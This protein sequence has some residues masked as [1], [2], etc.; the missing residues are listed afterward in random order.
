M[1]EPTVAVI[2]AGPAGLGAAYEVARTGRR[3]V[4]LERSD[5]IGGLARSFEL[6]G[7]PVELGAH[8]LLRDDPQIDALWNAIIGDRYRRV[9]RDTRIAIAGHLLQY[10]YRSGDVAR[11]LGVRDMARC[12]AGLLRR[13]AADDD[14]SLE[15]WV[16]SRFGR[17]AYELLLSDYLVKL[18]G[19][20]GSE[21]DPGLA[22]SLLGF[23][24]HPTPAAMV[25]RLL[26]GTNEPDVVRPLGG[27]GELLERLAV[28]I[29]AAGGEI[30]LG[31]GIDSIE[32]AAGRVAA[33]HADGEVSPV[34]HLISTLPP[35]HLLRLLP[36]VPPP[37]VAQGDRLT[38]RSVVILYARISGPPPFPGQWLYVADLDIPV[39][40]ITNFSAWDAPGPD[41]ILAFEI[42][43][44]PSEP[45][46][47]A[48]P[49]DLLAH[50]GRALRRAGLT[51]APALD[52][53][54]ERVAGAL[55]V[56]DRA[57]RGAME[58]VQ[59][60]VDEISGL[61]TTGRFGRFVNS[62]THE[63][64][65]LGMSAARAVLAGD[66]R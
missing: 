62:G 55:P 58:A 6:W 38:L 33:V 23:S 42:W 17:P 2:G 32:L 53:H 45:A 3:V 36:G 39:S 26:R 43:C 27:V 4:V 24:R 19:R 1:S 47:S 16:T 10:P 63:S 8:L 7:R 5:R 64:I 15:R 57:H 46:W 51:L 21:L 35:R 37:L 41:S 48:S 54:V 25:R 61:V 9:T 30:R 29:R 14:A 22:G 52:L 44:T 12:L 60:W 31:T 28:H 66:A 13:P 18:F 50:A 56:L 59:R 40:R 11:A 20:P 65:A 34:G 49:S